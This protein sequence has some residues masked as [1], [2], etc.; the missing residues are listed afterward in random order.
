MSR[1]LAVHRAAEITTKSR[2]HAVHKAVEK[3][4]M[5]RALAVHRAAEITTKSRVPAVHRERKMVRTHEH[6][7]DFHATVRTQKRTRYMDACNE[8][9]QTARAR[10]RMSEKCRATNKLE[11]SYST[12]V[13]PNSDAFTKSRQKRKKAHSLIWEESPAKLLAVTTRSCLSRGGIPC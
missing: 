6:T 11:S 9:M 13:P 7:A 4:A 5:S 3:K 2:A 12:V 8:G 10:R 1:V